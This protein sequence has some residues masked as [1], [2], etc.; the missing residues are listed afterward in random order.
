VLE[1]KEKEHLQPTLESFLQQFAIVRSALKE[2]GLEEPPPVLSA[3]QM[4]V[5]EPAA[6]VA[7]LRDL[8]QLLENRNSRAMNALQ[9]LKNAL[10]DPRFHDRLNQLDSAICDLD[11]KKS[12]SIVSQLIEESGQPFERG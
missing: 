8:L 4:E 1:A 3:N 10:H 9:A 11:Y 7:V 5:V 12:I 6:T 2:L